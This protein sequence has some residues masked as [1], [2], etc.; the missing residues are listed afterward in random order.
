MKRSI[1]DFKGVQ[2]LSINEQKAIKG[3]YFLTQEECCNVIVII[4]PFNGYCQNY[5][6]G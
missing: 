2:I 4:Q 6:C 1:L 5:I 3:S